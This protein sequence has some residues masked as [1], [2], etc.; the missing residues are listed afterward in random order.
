MNTRKQTVEYVNLQKKYNPTSN[1]SKAYYRHGVLYG[2]YFDLRI[3]KDVKITFNYGAQDY[4]K[5]KSKE[6]TKRSDSTAR[7]RV[8]IFRLVSGN[9]GRFGQFKP[10][11]GTYTFA[12]QTRSIDYA[13][14]RFKYYIKQLNNYLGYKAEYIVVPEKH[15]SGSYHFHSV[16]FNLPKMS[17]RDND[18]M[19]GQ[20]DSAVN[21][22]YARGVR[23]TGAYLAKYL[24]KDVKD[25][26]KKMYRTSKGIIRP[27]N[28][29]HSDTID[30]ILD[31]STIRV[32]SAFEGHTYT[33]TKYKLA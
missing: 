2:D 1:I 25:L 17:Y 26:N 9:V 31:S 13:N 14:T 10:I 4:N 16:F 27:I 23:D 5:T 32:L 12:E 3:Y 20:G 30:S 28:V 7:A 19:W 6:G 18:K 24:S 15:K 21:L 11:F 8:N 29:I 33:Q 22:Q